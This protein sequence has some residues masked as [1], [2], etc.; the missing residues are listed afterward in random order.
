[1]TSDEQH[2]HLFSVDID[3]MDHGS[4]HSG[5]LSSDIFKGPIDHDQMG[6]YVT[7]GPPGTPPMK[8]W[9]H[10]AV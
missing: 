3:E 4:V 1:M 7:H 9:D 6:G 8:N 2:V 5:R 10:T